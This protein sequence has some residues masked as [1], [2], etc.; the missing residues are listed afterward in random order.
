MLYFQDSNG[1]RPNWLETTHRDFYIYIHNIHCEQEAIVTQNVP[2]IQQ[3]EAF[4]TTEL[5]TEGAEK[6]TQAEVTTMAV[7]YTMP[8]NNLNGKNE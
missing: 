3:A 7:A 2:T 5:T 1:S 6:S 4:T 8:S